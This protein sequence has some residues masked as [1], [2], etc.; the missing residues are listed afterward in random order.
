MTD[1]YD[2]FFLVTLAGAFVAGAGLGFVYLWGLWYTVRRQATVRSPGLWLLLS[3][4]GRLA[5][6]LGGFYLVMNGSWQRL[7]ACTA[8]FVVVRLVMTRRLGPRAALRAQPA[9]KEPAP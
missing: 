9:A 8:G 5:L 6:L 3:V 1:G 7:I 4:A 2:A